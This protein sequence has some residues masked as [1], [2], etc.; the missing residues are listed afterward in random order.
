MLLTEDIWG[1]KRTVLQPEQVSSGE[2]F[3]QNPVPMMNPD[4]VVGVG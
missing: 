1:D 4:L 3:E 2:I